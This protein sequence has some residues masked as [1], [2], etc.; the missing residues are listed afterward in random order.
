MSENQS[1]D[2]CDEYTQWWKNMIAMYGQEYE[3]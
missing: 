3:D 1:T 2:E